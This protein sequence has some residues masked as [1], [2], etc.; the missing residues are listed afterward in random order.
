MPHD[1]RFA[2]RSLLKT[3][4][5]TLVA[6]LTL[7]LSI[8]ANTTIFGLI[9]GVLLTPPPFPQ[10]DR[11]VALRCKQPAMSWPVVADFHEY[12]DWQEQTDLFS[13]VMVYNGFVTQNLT[14]DAGARPVTTPTVSANFLKTLGLRPVL[15]RDLTAADC[16]PGAAPVALI[17][18]ALWKSQMH[19][20]SGVIG[21]TL[22]LSGR[23]VT[24][25]GVLPEGFTAVT[26]DERPLDLIVPLAYTRESSRRGNHHLW[27]YA[28]LKDGVSVAQVEHRMNDVALR[29]QKEHGITH[30]IVT[31]SL[32]EWSTRSVRPRLLTL[33]GSVA[34]VLLI[35]CVNLANLQ[36]VR[37]TG[38][39]AEI[40][41]KMAV[42]ASRWRIARELLGESLLLG[43]AGG[44]LGVLL[45]DTTLQ[46]AGGLLKTQF[47]TFAR[48]EIGPRALL[49]S[50]GLTLLAT[51]LSGL[52][53]AWRAT[54][55]WDRFM[56]AIGRSSTATPQQRRLNNLFIIAQVGLTLLVLVSAGLLVRSM[57]RLL[58]QERGFTAENIS[59]FRVS[60]PPARYGADAGKREQ[61]YT[62]LLGRLRALP[63]VTSAA[64]GDSIPLRSGTNGYFS[65]PGVTWV[66]GQEPLADKHTV[67]PGYFQN[68]GIP[69]LKGRDFDAAL[70]R[71]PTQSGPFSAAVIVNEAFAKKYFGDRDPVGQRVAY[72]SDDANQN[73]SQ[74]WDTVIGVVGNARMVALDR[75]TGPAMYLGYLQAPPS[76]QYIA[77]RSPLDP[78]ALLP[79]LREQLRALD[80]ELPLTQLTTM[81]VVVDGALAQRKLIT[82][83]VGSAAGVALALAM[84]GLYSV[85]AY[86][87]V[88]Q[89]REIGVRMALGARPEMIGRWILTHGLRL[90]ALGMLLGLA[91][92]FVVTRLL[93]SLIYDV[94][95]WDLP[96]YGGVVALLA[97]VALLACWLPARR[98]ARVDP[99]VALRAE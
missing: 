45:A 64:S 60:L 15:G 30:G 91:G 69:L 94:A 77:V 33:M 39:T 53:P 38:R 70:D 50:A 90:V 84:L 92:S 81:Q 75:P 31:M 76:T 47:A 59:V 51:A 8:G 78:A 79:V 93:G 65:V 29:L 35:A 24:V 97:T 32:Q 12:L 14:D 17:A 13:D 42:G 58:T 54:A 82:W 18:H 80:P 3:P 63:G 6:V 21:R 61:F 10:P 11:L 43:L 52:I 88:Q 73:P 41:I 5:F 98:A 55:S 1:L 74:V 40:S 83:T 36:L 62:Q 2:L 56:R 67:S 16:A 28:R 44:A 72:D 20:D 66:K 27:V 22:K 26:P 7:A 95:A 34:L 23:M 71:A 49:F 9:Q 46:L 89:T 99:L 25:V 4:G 86:T 37:I 68:F 85:I 57:H 19:S 96:T 48:F 87:V